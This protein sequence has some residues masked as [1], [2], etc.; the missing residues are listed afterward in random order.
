MS[1]SQPSLARRLALSFVIATTVLA[2]AGVTLALVALDGTYA[3]VMH[4]SR[5]VAGDL[6]RAANGSLAL[7][8]SGTTANLR[9]RNPG[10]WALAVDDRGARLQIGEPPRLAVRFLEATPATITGASGI[11][12]RIEGPGRTSQAR[13]VRTGSPAGVVRLAVGGVDPGTVSPLAWVATVRGIGLVAALMVLA[14]LVIALWLLLVPLVLNGLRPLARSAAQIDGSDPTRRLPEAGVVVELLPMVRAFNGA[15]DRLEDALERRARFMSDAAHELRTPLAVLNLKLED[16]PTGPVRTELRQSVFRLSGMVGQMLDAER[17]R[18]SPQVRRPVDLVALARTAVADVAPLAYAAGYELEL[19]AETD[20][21]MVDADPPSIRRALTNLLSNAVAHG[22]GCGMIEVRV[23]P[24]GAIE[25]SDAG[26]GVP[27]A[28]RERIFEPFH[29]VQW[30][31][32][33]CGLGLYLVR[34][35]MRLHGGD[36]ALVADRS[37]GACFR[38]SFGGVRPT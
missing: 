9:R 4:A 13:L 35:I 22:G 34:E 36:V 1:R 10:F 29:R 3:A 18:A 17:L 31:R 19:K 37:P 26:P 32:D 12:F 38:L 25:V 11:D 2:S 33:G 16:L 14:V 24:E 6:R 21:V 8:T 23:A 28:E 20:R 27:E 5:S 15:L 30:D 7:A